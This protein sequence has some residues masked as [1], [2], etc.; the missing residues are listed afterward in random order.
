[1]IWFYQ[2]KNIVSILLN[3]GISDF[4]LLVH[5]ILKSTYTRLK[6]KK[7]VHRC[8]R[9]ISQIDF[10]TDLKVELD[11]FDINLNDYDIF[12]TIFERV[13]DKHAPKKSKLNR[14]NEKPH[15][16]GELK[17]AVMKRSNL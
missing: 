8:L 16:T 10:E 1:M 17:K 6:P 5:T 14:G 9:K 4:H 12:E 3:T 15:M 2:I 11:N 13:L 7:I